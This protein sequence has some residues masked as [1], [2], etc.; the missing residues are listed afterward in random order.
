MT[1]SGMLNVHASLLPRY[2]GA[3]PII[4]AMRNGEKETGVSIMKIQPKT[5]DIGAVLAKRK[6]PIGDSELMPELHEKLSLVG[7]ELLVDVVKD[8]KNYQPMEQDNSQA[9]YGEFHRLL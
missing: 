6:V 9:S 1:F 4:Y 5:F 7:A 3:S 2:R 8:L